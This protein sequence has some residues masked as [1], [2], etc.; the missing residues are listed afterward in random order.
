[1]PRDALLSIESL[2]YAPRVRSHA[3][4]KWVLR[5]L[6][7]AAVSIGLAELG[8]YVDFG[9]IDSVCMQ[10]GAT[11]RGRFVDFIG[12]WRSYDWT[13]G[14]NIISKCIE[15][16][17][18]HAC[19]HQW[20]TENCSHRWG[21][22]LSRW[23][24]PWFQIVSIEK[25]PGFSQWI[26]DKSQSDTQFVDGLKA[27]VR[28]VTWDEDYWFAQYDQVLAEAPSDTSSSSTTTASINGS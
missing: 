14:S 21:C 11:R 23:R 27:M 24:H 12:Y 10:C 22:A 6:L 17:D 19:A 4:R 26:G 28:S 18:G 25:V 15:A 3:F 20:V 8:G 9:R 7:L 5:G 16:S 2:W 1:M 13:A